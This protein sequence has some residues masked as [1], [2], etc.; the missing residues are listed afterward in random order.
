MMLL[1]IVNC[2]H[3]YPT[4][5]NITFIQNFFKKMRKILLQLG[6]TENET[7]N[8]KIIFRNPDISLITLLEFV[9]YVSLLDPYPILCVN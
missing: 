8:K 7:E 1:G 2:E 3:G 4:P 9:I 5:N 6:E